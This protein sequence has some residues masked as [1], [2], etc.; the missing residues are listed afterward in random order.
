MK[1]ITNNIVETT[2]SSVK[3]VDK[4]RLRTGNIAPSSSVLPNE[5]KLA[6]GKFPTKLYSKLIHPDLRD[7]N[8]SIV[9]AYSLGIL[10]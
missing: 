2:L 8:K 9:S 10:A 7:S 1:R 3:Y 6:K 5:I 4:V